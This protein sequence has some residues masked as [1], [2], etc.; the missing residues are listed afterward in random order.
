MKGWLA[1]AGII[2]LIGAVGF[3]LFS[4][5]DTSTGSV[6]TGGG[7]DSASGVARDTKGEQAV[8]TKT[9]PSPAGAETSPSPAGAET[10][11]VREIAVEA[12][13]FSFSPA[14]IRVKEGEKVKLMITNTDTTH[15]IFLPDFNARGRDTLEFTATKK[16]TFTFYCANYCGL[17]HSGMQ[18]TLIVE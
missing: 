9:Q 8:A 4:Q 2:V 15:G 5:S 3:F 12:R 13:R 7:V 10:S 17:G 16:G 1:V 14:V 11:V 6:I 18:G